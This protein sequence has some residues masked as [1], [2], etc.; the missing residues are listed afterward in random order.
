MDQEN[1]FKAIQKSVIN[2]PLILVGSGASAPHGL[3]SMNVLGHHLI[4]Q[5]GGKYHGTPC[6]DIFEENIADGQDLETALT[7]IELTAEVLEDIRCETW[8]L[9]SSKDL[10]LFAQLLFSHKTLPL[11]RILKKFY[12]THPR[13]IDI[14][15][16][17][18]DR[19]VE[20]ACD[21]AEIPV[22]VGFNG[23]YLKRFSGSFSNKDAVNLLKV[24]GSLDVFRDAHGGVV[25]TS[26]LS[27]LPPGLVPELITPGS[28]K[29]AAILHGTPRELLL[30]ADE[31]I[32]QAR[33]FL[34][35]G[36]GFN[37]SQ[38]QEGILTRIRSGIPLVSITKK[39]SDSAA[40]LLANN[41][42]SYITIQQGPDPDKTEVC[43][44]R[45]IEVLDGE[46]WTIDGFMSIID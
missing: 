31:R 28:S 37:D 5:L 10:E 27:E 16:T 26:M 14:I 41:A 3:P 19:L 11:T 2:T 32:K 9:I 21:L 20:Y 33:S 25:S 13:R 36:Y 12:Q 40:H 1:I 43:I 29:Y 6:W 23:Q 39:V 7:G 8:N 46:F 45:S 34:C 24:H 4:A 30:V 42:Q 35:I 38:I 15:T 44:N 17:N 22:M 18:Y